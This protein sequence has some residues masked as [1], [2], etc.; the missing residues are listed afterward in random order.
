M[1]IFALKAKIKEEKAMMGFQSHPERIYQDPMAHA[2]L[3]IATTE[4]QE[5]YPLQIKPIVVMIR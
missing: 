1:T 5:I 4:A 2:M 3:G